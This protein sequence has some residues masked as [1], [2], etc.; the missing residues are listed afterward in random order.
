[1]VQVGD[2]N[3]FISYYFDDNTNFKS[4]Q[5]LIDLF[6]K[7]KLNVLSDN[8]ANMEL[9]NSSSLVIFILTNNYLNSN[10][11]RQEYEHCKTLKKKYMFIQFE[12]INESEHSM[13]LKQLNCIDMSKRTQCLQSNK[14]VGEQF[15]KLCYFIKSVYDL[16]LNDN[17]NDHKVQYIVKKQD[18]IQSDST[19]FE[20]IATVPSGLRVSLKGYVEC[21]NFF[22]GWTSD[23]IF[24]FDFQ[25]C[26]L[27]KQIE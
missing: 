14:W 12:C 21:E 26:K 17:E 20:L 15:N 7:A 24:N 5:E 8:T 11:F 25:S 13:L 16:N 10:K 2:F 4:I 3:L 22:I 18:N 9:L 6:Q 27:L 19:Q 23:E 1:M